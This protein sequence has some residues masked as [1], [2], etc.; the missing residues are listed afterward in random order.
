MSTNGMT[1]AEWLQFAKDRAGE[2][3]DQD[4][5][6]NAWSSFRSDM[7][8]HP[9]TANHS[10]LMLGDQHLFGGFWKTPDDARRF[11]NGYN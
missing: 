9:E 2:Y 3:L 1:R 8:K 4:D 5:V 11:I 10:A 7:G 6:P